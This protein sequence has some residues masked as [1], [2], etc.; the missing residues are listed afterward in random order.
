MNDTL[1]AVLLIVVGVLAIT[2]SSSAIDCLN[3]NEDYS[4][5]MKPLHIGLIGIGVIQIL[6]AF[7]L[8]YRS[9][10]SNAVA[11]PMMAPVQAPYY[12]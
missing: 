5:T 4:Q 10:R 9:T 6:V 2:A 12:A 1:V 8:V 3:S 7:F 11:R